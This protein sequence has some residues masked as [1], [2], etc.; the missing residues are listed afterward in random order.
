MIKRDVL[1]TEESL[2]F[3]YIT[4][5]ALD[6][7]QSWGLS[8]EN[9]TE[10]S[11]LTS[12][13]RYD[14]CT[15]KALG[16]AERGGVMSRDPKSGSETIL[17]PGF[18]GG[19]A[20]GLG[21]CSDLT[22]F[23]LLELHNSGLL[24]RINESIICSWE[25]G[26]LSGEYPKM[27][28]PIFGVGQSPK[29]FDRP[30]ATHIWLG[31]SQ[32]ISTYTSDM[33]VLDGAFQE[34]SLLSANGYRVNLS[35]TKLHPARL[36]IDRACEIPVAELPRKLYF[37]DAISIRNAPVL[38]ISADRLAIISVTFLRAGFSQ[39]IT[40]AVL[41]DKDY[42]CPHSLVFL[43][44]FRRPAW[45]G[46]LTFFSDIAIQEAEN[47]LSILGNIE[48]STNPDYESYLREVDTFTLR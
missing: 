12:R 43:D 32:E 17:L 36:T 48:L 14:L 9:V 24:H 16:I 5:D 45:R 18:F 38:G 23:Q 10:L 39:Q 37:S 40:P 30:E 3:P 15:Q 4:P 1:P 26:L 7:L 27:L 47:V 25:S 46:D 29:F 41:L 13:C 28:M 22:A 31:L 35:R 42:P 33:V 11:I 19:V 8:D 6:V 34:V 44:E 21:Q 20:T 2:P